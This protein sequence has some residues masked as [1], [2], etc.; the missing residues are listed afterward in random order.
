MVSIGGVEISY[1]NAFVLLSSFLDEAG[2]VPVLLVLAL[3]SGRRAGPRPRRPL[4]VRAPSPDGPNEEL[5]AEACGRGL[6]P[7]RRRSSTPTLLLLSG[8]GT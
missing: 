1:L 2:G 6:P 4:L 3:S 8:G 5:G 7:S